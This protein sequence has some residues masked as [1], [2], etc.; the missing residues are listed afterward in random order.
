[1][2]EMWELRRGKAKECRW[3]WREM[4]EGNFGDKHDLWGM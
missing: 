4:W 1:M 3:R 2:L